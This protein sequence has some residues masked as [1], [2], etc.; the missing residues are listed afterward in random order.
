MR[1]VVTGGAGFIGSNLVDA[2]VALGHDVLA[3]DNLWTHGGG[4][5]GNVPSAAE[6]VEMDIRDARVANVFERFRP[7]IIFHEAAQHSVAIAALDPKYDADVNVMGTLNVLEAGVKAGARKIVFASSA[8]TY[9][10]VAGL[11]VDERSIQIPI[12][13]YG[14]TKMIVEHYL[15]FYK[16]Q[17]GLDYTV[18]RYG[19]VFGP[20]QD[21]SGEAGV[22]AIFIDRFLRRAPIRIDWDGEQTRDYIYVDDVVRANVAALTKGSGEIYVIG[23][24][25]TT[26]VN[27]VY[28]SL[29]TAT[30]FA[31]PVTHAPRRDGDIREIYFD[32]AKAKHD[33]GWNAEVSLLE[34]ML[35]TVDFFRTQ[36]AL[37]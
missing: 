34:G 15:R 33:L 8:A 18:L 23:S 16:L 25:R 1:I 26:S 30:G 27:A 37:V 14:I 19:N 32:P 28:R 36:T 20:R 21:P 22:I 6:L 17:H 24:G 10:N 12:S 29:V 9:G 2:L 35:A 7:E 11:P 4:R 5:R 3:L 13:P 31:A